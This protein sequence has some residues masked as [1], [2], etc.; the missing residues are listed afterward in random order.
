MPSRSGHW[1]ICV[2]IP[3]RESH[4]GAHSPWQ[5]PGGLYEARWP[6]PRCVGVGPEVSIGLLCSLG[7]PSPPGCPPQ[8]SG[9]DSHS[10]TRPRVFAWSNRAAAS[11][12]HGF[13]IRGN[14]RINPCCWS[15]L[16][17]ETLG[18]MCCTGVGVQL[19]MGPRVTCPSV[20]PQCCPAAVGSLFACPLSL[21]QHCGGQQQDII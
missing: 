21:G 18:A 10:Q 20:C 16:V 12:H 19:H 3:A 7:I 15:L 11:P 2:S 14:H 17:P 5:G 9:F 8:Q 6:R 1:P 13:S 4:P